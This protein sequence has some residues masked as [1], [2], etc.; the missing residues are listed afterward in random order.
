VTVIEPKKNWF[1]LQILSLY[2]FL[3]A[4]VGLAIFYAA[5]IFPGSKSVQKRKDR[6]A[7]IAAQGKETVIGTK[8]QP[9]TATS[10]TTSSYDESWIPEHHLKARTGASSP[11]PKNSRS[12]SR[13]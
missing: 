12:N 6:K 3:A 5:Q 1:D 13:K 4:A 10:G 7:G 8:G 9:I 2:A 11:K